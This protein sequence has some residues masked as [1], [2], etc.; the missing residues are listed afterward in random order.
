VP[1]RCTAQAALGQIV[2]P[3][4]HMGAG[5]GPKLVGLLD[6]REAHEVLQR[7]LVGTPGRLVR[8]VGEPLDLGRHVGQALELGRRQ[9]A[10][11]GRHRDQGVLI[12]HVVGPPA[13]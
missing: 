4:N 6:A 3:S 7:G 13:P 1:D 9:Q 2:T 10:A 12:G 5:H 11:A 8:Q